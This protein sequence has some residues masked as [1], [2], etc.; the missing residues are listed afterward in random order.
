MK[1][2]PSGEAVEHRLGELRDHGLLVVVG[3][4][5]DQLLVRVARRYCTPVSWASK[6]MPMNNVME[7]TPSSSRVV[8]A[9][10]R[11]GLLERGHAVADGL[12][13]GQRRATRRERP[14]E[15][16]HHGEPADVAVLGVDVEPGGL[17]A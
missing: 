15:Q 3:G 12:D 1:K 10:R 4:R 6:M 14:R 11:L 8:A 17:G 5:A 9:L 7:M 13:A 16:E 2:N